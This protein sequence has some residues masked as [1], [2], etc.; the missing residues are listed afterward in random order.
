MPKS[1]LFENPSFRVYYNITNVPQKRSPDT[2]ATPPICSILRFWQKT[3]KHG[4][5][6]LDQELATKISDGTGTYP[7]TSSWKI[8]LRQVEQGFSSFFTIFCHIWWLFKVEL[9]CKTLKI[10][11][12][13]RKALFKCATCL[14]PKRFKP[15]F[16]LIPLYRKILRGRLLRRAAPRPRRVRLRRRI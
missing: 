4:S 7:G 1:A 8:G 3:L 15:M 13:W 2:L 6:E 11:Q 16:W 5:F 9:C 12:K 14:K 10:W